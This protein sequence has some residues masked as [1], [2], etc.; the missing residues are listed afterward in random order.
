MH[1]LR[2]PRLRHC[3][4][5]AGAQFRANLAADLLRPVA[6][7]QFADLIFDFGLPNGDVVL[8]IPLVHIIFDARY[9][10]GLNIPI[11]A[12]GDECKHHE[13]LID[14][15]SGLIMGK[16]AQFYIPLWALPRGRL[17]LDVEE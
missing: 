13:D 3:K 8:A 2:T 6:A 16:A 4:H 15:S 7:C 5:R 11:C 10:R 12:G 9:S 1:V 17:H 14:D